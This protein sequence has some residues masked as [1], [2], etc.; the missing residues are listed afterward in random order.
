[1]GKKV[2]RKEGIPAG[3]TRQQVMPKENWWKFVGKDKRRAKK[4]KKRLDAR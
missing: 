4:E 1:M 3:M 2:S